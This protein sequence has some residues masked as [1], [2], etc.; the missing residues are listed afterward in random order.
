MDLSRGTNLTMTLGRFCLV[1]RIQFLI[2]TI[3]RTRISSCN[4]KEPGRYKDF[5]MAVVGK[6]K[7]K[8]GQGSGQGVGQKKTGRK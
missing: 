6:G 2:W 4:R 8:A 7:E 5:E 3:I 1:N